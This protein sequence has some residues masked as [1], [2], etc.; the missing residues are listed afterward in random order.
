MIPEWASKQAKRNK[1]LTPIVE[2]NIDRAHQRFAKNMEAHGGQHS[3]HI[4]VKK[5]KTCKLDI[6]LEGIPWYSPFH[7][8]PMQQ[9]T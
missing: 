9:T 8:K 3:F 5:Y 2:L 1:Y 4:C 7:D 6:N